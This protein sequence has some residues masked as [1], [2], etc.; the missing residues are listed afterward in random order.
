MEQIDYE[1]AI[2]IL[3]A[4]VNDANKASANDNKSALNIVAQDLHMVASLIEEHCK[5][6]IKTGNVEKNNFRGFVDALEP[7][8]T[9]AV[10]N[11]V[12]L[13][14][15]VYKAGKRIPKG[16]TLVANN[17]HWVIG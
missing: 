8:N 12:T 16:T 13:S 6:H 10:G 1:Q 9:Y 3:P 4:L 11:Y 15:T 5:I 17:D 14:C 2:A 7:A